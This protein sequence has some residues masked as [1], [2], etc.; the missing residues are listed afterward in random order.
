MT[1]LQLAALRMLV[2]AFNTFLAAMGEPVRVTATDV[3]TTRR[4]EW[5]MIALPIEARRKR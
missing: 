2:Q 3:R 4:G 5:M 1:T